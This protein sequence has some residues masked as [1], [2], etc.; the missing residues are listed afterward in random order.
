MQKDLGFLRDYVPDRFLN[1]PL[2]NIPVLVDPFGIRK[3]QLP[4][5]L[6]A[7][8]S[9]PRRTE[10]CGQPMTHKIHGDH[11]G[12]LSIRCYDSGEVE[13]LA[14]FI[15]FLPNNMYS[16]WIVGG[17]PADGNKPYPAGGVPNILMADHRGRVFYRR[18]LNFLPTSRLRI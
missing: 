7:E 17:N 10:P 1:I 5:M 14:I 18:R 3:A 13:M 8:E 12:V 4:C 15:G 6:G 11:I 9:V 16:I 2:D